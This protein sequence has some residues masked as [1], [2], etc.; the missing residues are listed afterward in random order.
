MKKYKESPDTDINWSNPEEVDNYYLSFHNWKGLLRDAAT[1][2]RQILEVKDNKVFAEGEYYLP[3]YSNI[4]AYNKNEKIFVKDGFIFGFYVKIYNDFWGEKYTTNM[5]NVFVIEQTIT[6]EMYSYYTNKT[7]LYR[8]YLKNELSVVDYL[9]SLNKRY[10]NSV[11]LNLFKQNYVEL[12]KDVSF[13]YIFQGNKPVIFSIDNTFGEKRIKVSHRNRTG[14][15]EIDNGYHGR[16]PYNNS[17]YAFLKC[18]PYFT[19]VL[20]ASYARVESN[21]LN[22]DIQTLDS[23]A[24]QIISVWDNA[25][26]Q[27]YG[28]YGY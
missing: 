15:L 10:I 27:N 1:I 19:N 23:L 20:S 3:Y 12:F 9:N 16:M 17:Y 21:E 13:P 24:K 11:D 8:Q 18:S 28:N 5:V 22:F 14:Q 25:I 6:P 4:V 7:D 26:E 2:N